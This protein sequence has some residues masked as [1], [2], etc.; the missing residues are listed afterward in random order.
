[1]S[2]LSAMSEGKKRNLT[3]DINEVRT[4]KKNCYNFTPEMLISLANSIKKYGQL[5]NATVYEDETPNDGKKYTLIGGESRYRAI[6]SLIEQG[7]H[8]GKFNVTVVNKPE[9]EVKELELI[10][11]D[12]LQRHK[13]KEII[14]KEIEMY[15]EIYAKLVANGQKPNGQKRDWIGVQI[16]I[17]G[18][19]VDRYKEQDNK[20]DNDSDTENNN[21]DSSNNKANKKKSTI[22]DVEKAIKRNKKAIEK[23]IS[24]MEEV[25]VDSALLRTIL[26]DLDNISF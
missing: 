9:D 1:M 12:N 13:N 18:R 22:K 8:N 24:L 14:K 19:T 23:T 3:I 2:L 25:G 16:G 6:V 15:E 5:E 21:T 11:Q 17:S 20:N 26:L 7:Q 4:N 10:L